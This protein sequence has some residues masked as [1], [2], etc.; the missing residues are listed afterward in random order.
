M[1]IRLS[2]KIFGAFLLT[3]FMVVTLMVGIMQFYVSRQF[4]DY[5]N[6]TALDRLAALTTQLAAEYQAHQGWQRLKTDSELWNKMLREALPQSDLD[7][8]TFS[9]RPD[10]PP[11]P[12][13]RAAMSPVGRRDSSAAGSEEMRPERLHR[14]LHRLARALALFDADMQQIAGGPLRGSS[15]R[16]T[17][18]EIV[19]GGRTVGWLG[20]PKRERQLSPLDVSFLKEQSLAFYLIGGGILLLAAIVSFLLSRHFLA[21]VRRLAEGTRALAEFKFDTKIDVRTQDELGQL[22]AD[23]NRMA[24][25]LKKYE[26]LRRQW[27]SDISHELRTPLAI[28]KGE[29]EALQDGVRRIDQ[30]NLESL[31]A[32]V[33]RLSKMVEDLHQLALADSQT[34]LP[35]DELIE[36]LAILQE[37]VAHFQNRLAREGIDTQIELS[38]S[39]AVIVK[40]DADRLAQLFSNLLENTVNHTASPGLLKIFEHHTTDRLRIYFEDSGPGVPQEALE[41]LFDRLYRVD[42]SRSRK[43]GGSGLGLAICKQIV[44]SHGGKIRAAHAPSGGLRIEI[45]LPLK[46]R[47]RNLNQSNLG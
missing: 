21:P 18:Q 32:E 15:D 35:K 10:G 31:H 11:P 29:I 5:V 44:E 40:G 30:T 34:L 14:R 22:A 25:T 36:P 39:E 6:Q 13:P 1:K 26:E 19:V 20:L 4:A 43:R 24:R 33:Q 3:S 38:A 42:Q 41:R 47:D 16:Y 2:Y 28:L 9:F 8:A 12:A 37:M 7:R 23:F 27:I 17:S 46:R 45:E